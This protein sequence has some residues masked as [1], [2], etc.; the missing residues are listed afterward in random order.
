[1]SRRLA[2]GPSF[3]SGVVLLAQDQSTGRVIALGRR[4]PAQAATAATTL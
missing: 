4:E 2:L 3:G 1:M